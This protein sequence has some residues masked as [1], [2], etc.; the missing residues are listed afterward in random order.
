MKRKLIT[1]EIKRVKFQNNRMLKLAGLIKENINEEEQRMGILDNIDDDCAEMGTEDCILY[2]QDVIDYCEKEKKDYEAQRDDP[3][4]EEEEADLDE[5][6]D[7][8][9]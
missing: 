2:L 6:L 9:I 4:Y 3:E 7:E 8:Q 1:E 5:N